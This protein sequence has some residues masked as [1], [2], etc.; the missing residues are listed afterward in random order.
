MT[1]INTPTFF[2]RPLSRIDLDFGLVGRLLERRKLYHSL[3]FGS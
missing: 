2:D 1:S 3:E